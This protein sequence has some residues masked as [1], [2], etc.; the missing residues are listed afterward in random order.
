MPQPTMATAA[1]A[2]YGA[3]NY[4]AS[5]PNHHHLAA[6]ILRNHL[7]VMTITGKILLLAQNSVP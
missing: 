4:G 2:N 6:L 1:T 3:T 7:V 5:E